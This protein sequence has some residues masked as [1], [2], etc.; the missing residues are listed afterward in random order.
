VSLNNLAWLLVTVPV[1]ELRDKGHALILA[2]RAV[3]LE[4]SPVF[5][6]TLAEASYA[7]G[8]I[9]DAIKLIEEAITM[10]AEDRGYYQ[11][12]LEKFLAARDSEKGASA[13]RGEIGR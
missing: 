9:E 11:G 12:Q 5:L 2:R 7:N 10:A 8:L 6:D 3:A 4:R 1:K 13:E